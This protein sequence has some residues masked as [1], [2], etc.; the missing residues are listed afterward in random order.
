MTDPD[1]PSTQS[2]G[3][4]P[5]DA[6]RTAANLDQ[7]AAD[8]SLNFASLKLQ[9][10]LIAHDRLGALHLSNWYN[11]G[12]GLSVRGLIGHPDRHSRLLQRSQNTTRQ[13]R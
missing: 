12:G 5:G 4:E 7:D 11:N 2:P 6:P 10:Q 9:C 3:P 8:T 1:A 13:M